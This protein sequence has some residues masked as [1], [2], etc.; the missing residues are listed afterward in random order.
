MA[1]FMANPEVYY[2]NP[3]L[4]SSFM[5]E[6]RLEVKNFLVENG[7][8]TPI[9]KTAK[10]MVQMLALL[11][12]DV[13]MGSKFDVKIQQLAK[14][15]EIDILGTNIIL[16]AAEGKKPVVA[17]K[18]LSKKE[19]VVKTL[20]KENISKAK[21]SVQELVEKSKGDIDKNLTKEERDIFNAQIEV[22]SLDALGFRKDIGTPGKVKIPA[23]EA[24]SY[25]NQFLPGILRRYKKSDASG[26]TRQFSTLFY[27]NIKPKRQAFY[28]KQEKLSELGRQER[29]GDVDA[30]GREKR[31]VV[32][33]DLTP[34][35]AMVS[36]ES[37]DRKDK[38]TPRAKLIRDFPEI[39]D[40]EVKDLF[41]TAGL[42]IFE[43]ETPAVE[44][45]EFKGFTTEV[46]RQKTTAKIK[47][48][49]GTGKTYEFNVKKLAPKLKENLPI[50]WF[51]RMEGS[52]PVNE[53]KFTTPPKR[54]TKQADIDRAMLNDKVYVEVTTQGVNAYEFKDFTAKDLADFI[55]A[56]LVNPKTRAKSEVL[57]KLGLL[58]D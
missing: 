33:T 49:L 15:D 19:D 53:K 55:L 52:K 4:A 47:K 2:T 11:G 54:L 43:G 36:K 1:E 21:Q 26:K 14:L 9:P 23:S 16:E 57:E 56:P 58:K 13:R 22:M 51:V 42:E 8:K 25:A 12:K 27:G 31:D 28:G 34:E 35:E 46:F 20:S 41:E 40:Q 6:F 18:E 29:L 7:L 24:I 32:S 30:E 17:S 38:V 3:N 44:A 48:K 39:F 10:D 5:N 50:Q 45:K 37:Q